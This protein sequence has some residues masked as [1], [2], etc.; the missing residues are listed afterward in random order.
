CQIMHHL[1]ATG[2]MTDMYRILQVEMRGHRCEIVGIVVHVVPVAGLRRPAVTAPVMRDDTVA[3]SHEEHHLRIPVICREW[4]AMAE[5][6]GLPLSPIL[7]EDLNAVLRLDFAHGV[8]SFAL[9][10]R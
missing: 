3:A 7:V 2:G 5:N 10:G 9:A 6:D 4:P 1:A 8:L